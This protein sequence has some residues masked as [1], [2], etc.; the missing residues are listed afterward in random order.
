MKDAPAFPSH[1]SMGEVCHEGVT[2]REWFAAHAMQGILSSVP[3]D[4]DLPRGAILAK[5]SYERADAMLQHSEVEV[6][7][8]GVLEEIILLY[9]NGEAL[10]ESINKAQAI[11][12]KAKGE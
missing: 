10:F 6:E 11:L 1:G 8:A 4:V 12:Q 2:K 9:E 3:A 5:E 7:L